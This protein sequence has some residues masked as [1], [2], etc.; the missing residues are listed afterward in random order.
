MISLD[1][2]IFLFEAGQTC[3]RQRLYFDGFHSYWKSLSGTSHVMTRPLSHNPPH[4]TTDGCR[5]SMNCQQ[6]VAGQRR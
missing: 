2:D 6:L 1:S 3:E 5:Q 4:N